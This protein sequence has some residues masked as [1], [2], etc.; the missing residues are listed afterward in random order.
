MHPLDCPSWEY[1]DHPDYR[2]TLPSRVAAIVTAL[3]GGSI[4]TLAT[5]IDT[6]A[7]H[8]EM[9]R[10]LTPV[11]CDYFAGHYRGER[12]RCLQFYRVI[13]PSD[14][15]VGSYPSAVDFLMRELKAALNA[16]IVALDTNVAL[17]PKDRLHYA[18]ILA[19]KVFVHL[20][21][22]HPYANGNGHAGRL[23]VWC[24]LGRYG[25]WPMHWTIEPQPPNPPYIELIARYRSGDCEPLENHIAQ[26]LV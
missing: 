14:P 17:A 10:G 11:N 19:C 12:F 18:I 4:N 7:Q 1:K 15:R 8:G 26:W 21:T 2:A 25:D 16:G 22:I 13:I 3:V 5:A 9:F 20:L 6:R 23:V 24:V